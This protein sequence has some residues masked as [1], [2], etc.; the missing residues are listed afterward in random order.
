MFSQYYGTLVLF[1]QIAA[2]PKKIF[3]LCLLRFSYYL[4]VVKG[5]GSKLNQRV[6]REKAVV[7]LLSICHVLHCWL[8]TTYPQLL[9]ENAEGDLFKFVLKRKIKSQDFHGSEPD[10]SD[11]SL[12]LDLSLDPL[13]K[14]RIYEGKLEKVKIS[15]TCHLAYVSVLCCY[16]AY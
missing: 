4:P 9:K 1:F 5:F 2:V 3:L 11:P 16:L 6:E 10:S 14:L 15:R 13:E 7:L 12:S 8:L